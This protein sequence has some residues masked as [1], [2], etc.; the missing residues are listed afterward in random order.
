MMVFGLAPS[1]RR[2]AMSARFSVTTTTSVDTTLNMA[3]VTINSRMTNI[4]VFS[5]LSARKKLPCSRV[6]S[7]AM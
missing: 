6:Q 4:T 3:T 1:V 5:I 7:R 2:M